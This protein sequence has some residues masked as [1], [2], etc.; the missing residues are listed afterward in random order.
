[1]H[2]NDFSLC[3]GTILDEETILTAAHCFYKYDEKFVESSLGKI[4]EIPN[5]ETFKIE[6]G[7]TSRGDGQKVPVKT[8]IIHPDYT[9][10]E[11]FKVIDA[12]IMKL[13][14]PL[15]FNE[16]VHP[17]CLPDPNFAPDEMGEMAYMRLAD[18]SILYSGNFLAVKKHDEL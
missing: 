10:F 3:G 16:N 17:A 2:L 13:K 7:M 14:T 8:V 1:M 12:V 18:S 5:S 11:N 4:W 6:A 15:I 9:G